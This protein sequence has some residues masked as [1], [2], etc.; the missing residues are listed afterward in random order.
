MPPGGPLMAPPIPC[1]SARP[2]TPRCRPPPHPA[3]AASVGVTHTPDIVSLFL[4][5]ASPRGGAAAASRGGA[6]STAAEPTAAPSSSTSSKGRASAGSAGSGSSKHPAHHQQHR[7]GRTTAAASQ[8][9]QAVQGAG[10][11]LLIVA[12]DGLWEWVGNADAVA[13]ASRCHTPTAA[14]EALALEAQAQ[15]ALRFGGEYCDDVT[16]A[17]A[18][19]P[20]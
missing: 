9:Q 10:H 17:V 3:V 8:A 18:F 4:P 5:V 11:H 6:A 16:V 7:Q 20:A 1:L 15:W 19:L 14:A 12:S 13:I 2:L